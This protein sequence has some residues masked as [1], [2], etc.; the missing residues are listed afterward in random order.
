MTKSVDFYF[1]FGSPATF[2]AYTQIGKIAERTGAQLNWKPMLLGGVFK[3]T[4][5]SSPVLIPA[6]GRWM[7]RDLARWAEYYGTEISYPKGFP[8]NTLPLMR[9]AIGY[10]REDEA[11]FHKY[12][13]MVFHAIWQNEVD[14]RD[15]E[16]FGALLVEHGFDPGE[17]LMMIADQE[18]K[19][20]LIKRT[21]EAVEN[22]IFGAPSFMIDGVLHFGQDRL[23]WVEE[24]LTD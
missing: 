18:V 20:D 7:N 13:S 17:F 9:G 15:Q 12:V 11:K 1:D 23:G 4:G 14:I 24:A 21:Q 19:D 16:R 10:L 6:K 2:L 22:G 3:A 5:N 8:L